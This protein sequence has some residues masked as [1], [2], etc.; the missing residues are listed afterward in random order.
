MSVR[1]LMVAFA[2]VA[3]AVG[4]TAS[5]VLGARSQTQKT[6][7]RVT[8]FDLGFR[9]S[10]KRAPHGVVSFIVKNTGGVSHDFK[11]A[12]K[13]TP[14]LAHNKS[15]TLTVTLRKGKYKYIC[16]VPGHAAGGMSGTFTAT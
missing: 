3:A 2:V 13:K 8:A 11:I 5:S 9:L 16:T 15:Y 12:G 7:V 4:M 10:T 1:R 14:R 6:T